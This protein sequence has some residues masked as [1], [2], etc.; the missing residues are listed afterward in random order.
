MK[1]IYIILFCNLF[2]FIYKS[3]ENDC[4]DFK[5]GTFIY[6]NN[7]E[8]TFNKNSITIRTHN[9]Q[10]YIDSKKGDTLSYD[11]IWISDCKYQLIHTYTNKKSE[12][13]VKIGDTLIVTIKPID[14][15]TY[16]YI[17]KIKKNDFEKE[18]K[19]MMK[20]TK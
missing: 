2:S 12:G 5:E 17:S 7:E 20:K 9:K 10:I 16:K 14:N 3:S 18:F 11:L 15:L 4:S 6:F 1:F 13:F 8:N 19:G